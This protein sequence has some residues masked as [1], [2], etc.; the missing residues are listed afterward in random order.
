MAGN[1]G[2]ATFSGIDARITIAASYWETAEALKASSTA[3]APLRERVEDAAGGPLTVEEYEV[4]L[5]VR[6]SVPAGGGVV[7]LARMEVDP[8]RID[9][10]IVHFREETA[11]RLQEA[12]GLCSFQ[13]LLDR[14]SGQGI[15]ATAW[16]KES[17]A[18]GFGPMAQQLR[19][20]AGER[21]GA[22]FTGIEHYT[23]I[24]TSVQLD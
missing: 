6:K 13:L 1:K 15:V 9:E 14:D 24:H 10:A 19:A 8:A 20:Q 2:L 17:A 3:L 21:V 18:G 4:A 11:P 5:G 22:R 12:S 23:M 16:E 7:R